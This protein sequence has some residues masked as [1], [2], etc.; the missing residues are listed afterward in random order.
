MLLRWP[1]IACMA[2]WR[3]DSTK[4]I[5]QILAMNYPRAG[6]TVVSRQTTHKL[7]AL[8]KLLFEGCHSR[9]N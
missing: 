2:G 3:D 7:N 5:A 9:N 6:R 8:D 1:P 4:E